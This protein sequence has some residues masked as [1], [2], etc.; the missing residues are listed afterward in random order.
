MTNGDKYSTV[1]FGGSYNILSPLP[2]AAIKYI[3][4]S[5]YADDVVADAATCRA[6]GWLLH[7]S[8]GHELALG[9]YSGETLVNVGNVSF[10][11]NRKARI[12][13]FLQSHPWT[14][15]IFNDNFVCDYRNFAHNFPVYDQQNHL[16]WS[17]NADFQAAQLSYIRNIGAALKAAGYKV[18]VNAK[19]FHPDAITSDYD[20]D[21]KGWLDQYGSS[22]T[23]ATIEYWQQNASNH[24]VFLT[25]DDTWYHHWNSWQE[26][27]AYANS[28]GIDPNPV[29]Y[30]SQ[31]ELSQCRYLRG[32]YLLEWN[33]HGSILL[34]P[35]VTADI[36]N[37]CT[38]FD[39]GFPSG[40]K[41]QV[42]SG[43]WRRNFTRGYV[44]VNPTGSTVVVGGDTIP[45]GGA[46]LHQ[47]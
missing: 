28:K 4:Q 44:I 14:N 2:G 47:G 6:N 31:T 20:T 39:P 33:G 24:T 18:V 32:S 46:V 42:A 36:W 41:Y 7:D 9:S 40:A 10:Q 43:V 21:S 5:C 16:L 22:V 11:N 17:S 13:N 1:A 26:F 23:G 45:S 34:A 3:G 38:A 8:S 29:A 27:I 19:C 25:G 30:I 15:G 12:L 37:T 35:W